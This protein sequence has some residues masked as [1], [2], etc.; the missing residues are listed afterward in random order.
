MTLSLIKRAEAGNV[1]NRAEAESVMEELLSGRVETAEIVRLLSAMNRW[2]VEVQELIGFSSVMRQAGST[3]PRVGC[4]Q[5][6]KAS[7]ATHAPLW[8]SISGW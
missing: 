1:L 8:R 3:K 6:T 2:P 4:C 7:A 5:R